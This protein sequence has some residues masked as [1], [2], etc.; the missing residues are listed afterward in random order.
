MWDKKNWFNFVVIFIVLFFHT[1][2][3]KFPIFI[4]DSSRYISA[5]PFLKPSP[6]CSALVFWLMHPLTG[7][8]GCWGVVLFQQLIIAYTVTIALRF[9]KQPLW[10]VLV[11]IFFSGMGYVS[12]AILMDSYTAAGLIALF[13]I[14]NNC[15][16]V[17]LY[18]I[19]CVCFLAHYGNLFLFPLTTLCFYFFVKD[20]K[21]SIKIIS[22]VLIIFAAML[23]LLFFSHQYEKNKFST[24]V[25][26][27]YEWIAARFLSDFPQ[28]YESYVLAYPN[29][30]LA[31]YKT[32]YDQVVQ[33][34]LT[35]YDGDFLWG[36]DSFVNNFPEV[37]GKESEMFVRYVI[38]TYPTQVLCSI[39]KNTINFIFR[40]PEIK[41]TFISFP[42]ELDKVLTDNCPKNIANYYLS[43]IQMPKIPNFVCL[44]YKFWYICILYFFML[45]I[46]LL[47]LRFPI[48]QFI[49]LMVLFSFISFIINAILCGG[50]V[51]IYPRYQIRILLVQSLATT[52]L[53]KEIIKKIYGNKNNISMF[54]FMKDKISVQ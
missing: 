20:K 53:I 22:V 12:S 46:V 11:A 33:K 38:S 37:C 42:E 10:V 3:L 15:D 24:V 41:N 43:H 54:L 6:H 13:L 49:K 32:F 25:K 31:S 16:D 5:S 21:Y 47:C 4:S 8:F 30:K 35:F 23:T 7:L 34:K 36:N 26:F 39:I 52:I 44:A 2:L 18:A 17:I 28:I 45:Y 19:L 9:L 48:D 50:F 40:I 1:I 51:G 27:E 14:L 29:R